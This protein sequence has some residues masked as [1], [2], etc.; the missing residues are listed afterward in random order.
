MIC[1]YIG[2]LYEIKFNN[3]IIISTQIIILMEDLI[4]SLSDYANSKDPKMKIVYNH[5]L[6]YRSKLVDMMK[7]YL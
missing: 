4:S 3:K 7:I 2:F 1:I 6:D 5:I